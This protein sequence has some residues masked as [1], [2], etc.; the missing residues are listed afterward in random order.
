MEGEG[1]K[2]CGRGEGSVGGGGGGSVVDDNFRRNK[3][4]YPTLDLSDESFQILNYL[5]TLKSSNNNIPQSPDELPFSYH[6]NLSNNNNNNNNNENKNDMVAEPPFLFNMPGT[7]HYNIFKPPSHSFEPN[8]SPYNSSS[9]SS[10][11][12]SSPSIPYYKSFYQTDYYQ[13]LSPS[14]SSSCCSSVSSPSFSYQ[15]LTPPQMMIGGNNH[16]AGDNNRNQ[17]FGSFPL[18]YDMQTSHDQMIGSGGLPFIFNHDTCF[19]CGRVGML[20][21]WVCLLLFMF[22]FDILY[23]WGGCIYVC[24]HVCLFL[25]V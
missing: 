7:S 16:F 18:S 17:L 21:V 19:R 4:D 5:S 1:R 14:S 11:S 6:Q 13:P 23:V 12:S 22:N 10:S 2:D 24:V 20:Y 3:N 9:S 25:Y 15:S 8:V